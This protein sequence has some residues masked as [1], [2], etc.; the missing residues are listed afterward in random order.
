[1]AVLVKEAEDQVR[2]DIKTN[3]D[4]LA[5]SLSQEVAAVFGRL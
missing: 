2:V 3:D 1:V 5:T 4:G